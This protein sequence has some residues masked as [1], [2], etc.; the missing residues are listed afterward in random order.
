MVGGRHLQGRWKRK[1]LEKKR[2]HGVYPTLEEFVEFISDASTELNDPV[3]GKMKVGGK[4]A[5][6]STFSYHTQTKTETPIMPPERAEKPRYE[7]KP[8]VL[9]GDKHRLWN[10]KLFKEMRIEERVKTVKEHKLCEN[11]LRD[12]HATAECRKQSVCSVK[13]CGKKHTKFLHSDVVKKLSNSSTNVKN[14]NTNT[15]YANHIFMPI[16][17]IIDNDVYSTYALLDNASTGTFCSR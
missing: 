11:C 3:Y 1:A 17:P 5:T 15:V 2:E 16:V 14:V 8:C 12:N 7:E 13:G 6:E 10:C 9:C 4:R